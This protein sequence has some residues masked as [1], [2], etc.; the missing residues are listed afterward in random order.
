MTH[1]PAT[2]TAPASVTTHRKGA[3]GSRPALPWCQQAYK[4]AHRL[5]ENGLQ[6][7]SMRLAQL[8]APLRHCGCSLLVLPPALARRRRCLRARVSH[9]V[10]E[11]VI[12]WGGRGGRVS[13][14]GRAA[15]PLI[16]SLRTCF[17]LAPRHHAGGALRKRAHQ[18]P[19]RHEPVGRVGRACAR[20]PKAV[21]RLEI[22]DLPSLAP[23]PWGDAQGPQCGKRHPLGRVPR[24]AHCS[25]TRQLLAPTR[26]PAPQGS[27]LV[28]CRQSTA[29]PLVDPGP[30]GGTS[31]FARL[32]PAQ[33]HG[34]RRPLHLAAEPRRD[35][36]LRPAH[37]RSCVSAH[38][39]PSQVHSTAATHFRE[40]SSSDTA[41]H[42]EAGRVGWWEPRGCAVERAA[43]APPRQRAT[44]RRCGAER[45]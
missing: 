13:G 44:A 18:Q 39:G 37:E 19:L 14:G 27:R 3:T 24:L 32:A 38:P 34:R 5:A 33:V 15:L 4:H 7:G 30:C 45:A 8:A 43:G 10:F 40:V 26:S 1:A 23:T 12:H 21:Q 11:R 17:E 25:L 35:G 22:M 28:H 6:S 20:V 41:R 2:E 29:G 42:C 9:A 16:V 36:R 31:S